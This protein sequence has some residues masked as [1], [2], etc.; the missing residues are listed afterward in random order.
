M[1]KIEVN[2]NDIE[3]C[4]EIRKKYGDSKVPFFGQNDKGE[5]VII[6]V[7]KDNITVETFQTNGWIRTNILWD[8]GL[9]E[10]LYDR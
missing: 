10:E 8:D 5:D 9:S 1:M 6:S 7:N 4:R 2:L 3:A